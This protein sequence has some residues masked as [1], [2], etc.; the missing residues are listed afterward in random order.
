MHNNSQQTTD[1]THRLLKDMKAGR[2]ISKKGM[3]AAQQTPAAQ[4][5][6]VLGQDLESWRQ[7]MWKYWQRR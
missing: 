3:T 7:G 2:R 4:P 6:T 1:Y 5:K